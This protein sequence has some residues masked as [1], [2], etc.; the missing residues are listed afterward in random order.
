MA[1]ITNII[2]AIG[3]NNST[4]PL[5]VRDC[6]IEV[7]TK[8]YKTYNQ[9]KQ[10][11]EI[12]YLATRER[13]VDEYATSAVWLGCI[14]LIDKV[15]NKIIK[16]KGYAPEVNVRLIKEEEEV[17]KLEEQIKN[18]QGIPNSEEKIAKLLKQKEERQLQSLSYN[19]EKFSKIAGAEEAVNGL[20]KVRANQAV[21][22]RLQCNKFIAAM[23]IPIALMGFII[24]KAVFAMTANT[25]KKIE[26]LK[27]EKGKFEIP[28]KN[29]SFSGKPVFDRFS[30]KN[31]KKISFKGGVAA[32]VC[33]FTTVE[34]MAITDGGYAV[35]RVATARKKNERIDLAFKMIGMLYLNFVAPK[36]LEKGLG[37][38][39][40]K[41]FNLDI[42]LDPI[43]LA[44]KRLKEQILNG[45]FTVPKSNSAKDLLE[46]IDDSENSKTLFMEYA[47]KFKKVSMLKNGIRDPRAYVDIEDLGKFRDNLATFSNR[48]KKMGTADNPSAKK[49]V[50][51]FIKKAKAA[52]TFNILA[53]VG[54]SS[55]LLA[56]V[57]PDVQFAFRELVTGSKLE[58]GLISTDNKK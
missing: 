20:E 35:G 13:A 36:Q 17:K 22:K 5:L 34:K 18:L 7:P 57:L 45:S 39:T 55:Y 51:G 29:M 33:N 42:K 56:S 46:F 32:T 50:D 26:T 41:L 4:Y 8:I 25:R 37:N 38:I 11:K 14:P 31:P 44:D 6:G 48:I 24:P 27:E 19:I 58:P 54:I 2:S 49:L 52:K 40:Q 53:N 12:A 47:Q 43:I 3:N 21:Y 1:I 23:A 10:D 28:E 15:G 9:N 30:L 16:K